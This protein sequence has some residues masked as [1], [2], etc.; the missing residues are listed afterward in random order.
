MMGGESEEEFKFK[1]SGR[2]RR[3]ITSL[4]PDEIDLLYNFGHRLA[5]D[6]PLLKRR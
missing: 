4:L 1:K 3:N 2:P 5:D 6:E